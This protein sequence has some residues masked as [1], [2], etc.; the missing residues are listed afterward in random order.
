MNDALNKIIINEP[1][2]LFK[3]YKKVLFINLVFFFVL[4][5]K[6]IHL[7]PFTII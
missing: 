3:P 4:T 5:L 7:Y 1:K 2:I 6:Q